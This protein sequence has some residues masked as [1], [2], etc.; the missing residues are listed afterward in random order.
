[1]PKGA[2]GE[3]KDLVVQ[4]KIPLVILG[5]SDKR[6]SILPQGVEGRH[7]LSGCKAVDVRI[8]G[9]CLVDVL[10][11]RLRESGKFDPITIAGPAQA[12]REAGVSAPVIDTDGGFGENIR[13]SVESVGA[14]QG[15]EMAIIT[16]DI[17]PE[18]EALRELIDDYW[19]HAPSDLWFPIVLAESEEGL[20]ASAWKPR[21]RVV[22]EPGTE[23]VSILPGHLVIC[24]PAILRLQFIYRFFQL[25]YSTRNRPIRYR[26]WFIARE[27]LGGL[28]RQDLLH[29]LGLQMPTL[30]WDVFLHGITAANHLRQGIAS[31]VELQTAVRY[32]FV[33][34][35][36]RR[37]HPESGVRLVLTRWMSLARDI[38]TLEEAEA[39]GAVSVSGGGISA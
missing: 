37:Q 3:V 32:M 22:R 4:R 1:L 34:R 16:C 36:H 27:A 18:V 25:A 7:P 9:R 19:S 10:L 15:Q 20:G 23:A 38:D 14:Q 21:Y 33:K 5:G 28:L 35:K 26:K 2:C 8:D 17:L 11:D 30:T 29:I 13:A 39:I 31:I 12:Y 24:N 6:P